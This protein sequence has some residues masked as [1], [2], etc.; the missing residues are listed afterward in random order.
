MRHHIKMLSLVGTTALGLYLCFLLVVPFSAPIVWA[1]MLAVLFS[2]VQRWLE[3]KLR[4]AGKAAVL[5]VCMIGLIVI[6]PVS[7][8]AQ[9][10]VMQAATGAALIESRVKS[11]EW[12]RAIEAQPRLA[13]IAVRIEQQINLQDTAKSL[14]IWLSN[15]AGSIVTGSLYQ[16]VSFFLT[17]YLLFF[18]LRDRHAILRAIRSLSPL[19]GADMHHLF[20]RVGDT[21]FATIYGTLAMSSVQ[22]LLGGLMFWWLGLSSPLLWGVVMAVLAVIPVLGA[23]VVWIPAALFLLVDGHWG[24]ALILAAWGLLVVGMIDNLLRPFLMGSRI[25][26]HTALVFMSIVGGL[27]VF[28]PEGLILGPVVIETTSVLLAAWNKPFVRFRDKQR[29]ILEARASDN[30]ENEGGIT[31]AD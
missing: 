11:G 23:F 19:A 27:I 29:A 20:H 6:V 9:R 28:G 14:A 10:L 5:A 22:G 25:K 26:T 30:W 3:K 24:K 8:V 18:L 1:V 7:F 21:I 12:R 13:P 2:P 31:S 15:L 4:S 16:V 17:L